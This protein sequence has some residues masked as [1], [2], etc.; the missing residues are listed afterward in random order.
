MTSPNTHDDLVTSSSG[1]S[2]N[3]L[4]ILNLRLRTTESTEPLLRQLTGTL[5][6]AVSEE[7]DHAAL[8]WCKTVLTLD[9]KIQ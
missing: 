4:E 7:F 9:L 6:L 3:V 2:N 5:V 8:I 1:L